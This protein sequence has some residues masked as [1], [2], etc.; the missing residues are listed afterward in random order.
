MRALL[1]LCTITHARHKKHANRG[2]LPARAPKEPELQELV[3]RG[4]RGGRRHESCYAKMHGVG[5]NQRPNC[6]R[7][8]SPPN[9]SR[10]LCG[11]LVAAVYEHRLWQRL[12]AAL[13]RA[14]APSVHV[15]SSCAARG[16]P[17]ALPP[18]GAGRT[19]WKRFYSRFGCAWAPRAALRAVTKRRG[20][21]QK[22][23]VQRGAGVL[24]NF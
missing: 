11:A 13:R 18:P 20:V 4:V 21:F 17:C 24:L 9:S 3:E 1:L 12:E 2:W 19:A 7:F 6:Y 8:V 22:L 15:L 10:A 5:R 14:A 23:C 16:L